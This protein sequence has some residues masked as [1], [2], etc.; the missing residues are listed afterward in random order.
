MLDMGFEPQIREVLMN[1]PG[2]IRR[3]SS[4]R[5]CRAKLGSRRWRRRWAKVGQ[6]SAP[7][8]NVSQHLEKV[9]DAEKVN[10]LV[11]TLIGEQKKRNEWDTTCP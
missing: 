4:R 3:C 7:T 9:V 6:M 8:A 1:L 10:R 2:L 5:R 11:T